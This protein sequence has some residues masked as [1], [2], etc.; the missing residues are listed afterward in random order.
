LQ[1]TVEPGKGEIEPQIPRRPRSSSKTND[2]ESI[3]PCSS[4]LLAQ[5][6]GR[7]PP[8]CF[9]KVFEVFVVQFPAQAKQLQLQGVNS[10]EYSL[11]CILI[12]LVRYLRIRGPRSIVSG[13]GNRFHSTE[14]NL[15]LVSLPEI[16]FSPAI[17]R[18]R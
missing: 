18:F 14:A 1:V 10:Y 3:L 8:T 4:A 6:C 5:R 9:F 11:K 12:Q 2:V 13:S 16:G 15:N 17:G 7:Q